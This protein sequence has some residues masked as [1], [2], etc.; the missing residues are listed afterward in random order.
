M[1]GWWE[2][3]PPQE[4]KR[5]TG[6]IAAGSVGGAAGL[7][8]G[9]YLL[10]RGKAKPKAMKIAPTFIKPK[11]PA[12]RPP[13]PAPQKAPIN[14]NRITLTPRQK[15][16]ITVNRASMEN[17]Q[18]VQ[19]S[20]QVKLERKE[21]NEIAPKRWQD[22]PN[23]KGI[24]ENASMEEVDRL[25]DA[26]GRVPGP[27]PQKLGA[28][29]KRQQRKQAGKDPF[30]KADRRVL[31]DRTVLDVMEEIAIAKAMNRQPKRDGKTGRFSTVNTYFFHPDPKLNARMNQEARKAVK[32]V[33]A[34]PGA[35]GEWRGQTDPV[36]VAYEKFVMGISNKEYNEAMKR[37]IKEWPMD[38]DY[39][40]TESLGDA[41]G[42]EEGFFYMVHALRGGTYDGWKGPEKAPALK[43]V[44]KALTGEK[45]DKRNTKYALA[46]LAGYAV[47]VNAGARIGPR[48][49]GTTWRKNR[50]KVISRMETYA[51]KEK[52]KITARN[53]ANQRKSFRPKGKPPVNPNTW[54]PSLREVN[55]INNSVKGTR[56]IV[57]GSI[58][59]AVLGTA[60]AT[61]LYAAHRNKK[62]NQVVQ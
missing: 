55:R 8:A 11:T 42:T 24:P 39:P 14:V 2:E 17:A 47:G 40:W 28:K 58:T 21:A 9:V 29:A 5:H 30:A 18:R 46:G 10:T 25:L 4:K 45:G 59:G 41:K 31:V 36:E 53:A 50:N 52:A 16:K 32:Y 60:G 23:L 7:A 49:E 62:R 61:A 27:V 44:S 37:S 56:G 22:D 6:A 54:Q 33:K 12:P 1:A 34:N 13:K 26:P 35:K 19:Q 38:D 48:F 3:K 43:Q 20:K 51:N 15:P 57:A